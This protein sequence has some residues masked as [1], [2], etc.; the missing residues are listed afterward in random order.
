MSP[1]RSG[2]VT[3][4][5]GKFAASIGMPITVAPHRNAELLHQAHTLQAGAGALYGCRRGACCCRVPTCPAAAVGRR[6][7]RRR[8]RRAARQHYTNFLASTETPILGK[9]PVR[10]KRPRPGAPPSPVPWRQP[11]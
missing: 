1:P 4:R 3:I 11:P 8:R 6:C 2:S 7:C 5:C 9:L 10:V